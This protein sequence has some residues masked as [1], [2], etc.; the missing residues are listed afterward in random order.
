M[1]NGDFFSHTDPNGSTVRMRIDRSNYEWRTYGENIAAGQITP[2][3]VM[4]GWM[5]SSGHRANILNASFTH[6]GVGYSYLANDT[7]NVNY[8]HY[9]TQVFGAGDPNP[10][11]YVAQT[12]SSTPSVASSKDLKGTNG[13]DNLIGDN[14]NENLYGYAGDD[15]LKGGGGNDNFFAGTESD[16]VDGEAGNDTL[17]GGVGKDTLTGGDGQDVISGVA[18]NSQQGSGLRE[19]DTLVGGASADTFRVGDRDRVYYNDGQD[20]T[21]GEADYALIQDFSQSAG[22]VIQLRGNA[23]SYTLGTVPQGLPTGTA[24]FL[25]TSSQDELIAVVQNANNLSLSSASFSYV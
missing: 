13:N 25:K 11:T 15:T 6:L 12:N 5:N 16:R 24:I 19:I 20:N 23:A 2:E 4:N 17:F 1:A 7:G 18:A 22:D 9:W 14:A 21:R 10:G 3:S 8:R